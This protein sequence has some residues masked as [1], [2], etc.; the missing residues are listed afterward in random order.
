VNRATNRAVYGRLFDQVWLWKDWPGRAGKVD[1]G[2]DLVAQEAETG[3][4][5]AIQCKFYEPDHVLSKPDVDSF[6]STSGKHPFAHRLII[7]TTDR[8]GPN[9][10]DAVDN[11]QIPVQRIGLADIAEAPIDWSFASPAESL[12]LDLA[13]APKRDPWPHQRK[14]IDKVIAEFSEHDRGKLIMACGTGKTF[15]ALKICE[16]IAETPGG[17]AKVLFLVPS[18]SLLSQTLR[19][20]TAQCQTDL[21]SFAVCSDTKVSRAVEDI[22]PYDVPLPATTDAATLVAQMQHRKRA[23]GFTVVFSTYQSIN[24]ISQA[25]AAGLDDFDVIICDEAHR[26]TGVTLADAVDESNFVKVHDATFLTMTKRLYMTAT[27]RIFAEETKTKAAAHAAVLASMDDEELYGPTF[28]RLGF[29]EAVEHGLLTDYKVLVLTVDEK[30]IADPLQQ[31]LADTNSELNLDD[32]T[33]IVGCWNGL[34]KRTGTAADGADSAPTPG[35]CSA[36]SHSCATLRPPRSWPASSPPSSAPTTRPTTRCCAATSN[37]STAPTT[38]WN[39]T[40][41]CNGSK[42]HCLKTNAASWPTHAACPKGSTS[43]AWTPSCSSTHATQW[44]TSCSLSAV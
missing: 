29:G 32:A 16:E 37:T 6:L 21:R 44:L 42:P 18:I 8:W 1:T 25:Q 36:R 23:K 33:K 38:H 2:I 30:Y 31:Q 39:V 22:N 20:W 7:S 3:D 5:W 4:L 41:G 28:H 9:A 35:P 14:A 17:A 11:Q 27:P 26:T 15:T 12:D 40:T 34:A 19:E 24:T 10:E 13:P 43:P